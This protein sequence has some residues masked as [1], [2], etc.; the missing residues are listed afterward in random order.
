MFLIR[1][2]IEGLRKTGSRF[3]RGH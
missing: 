2:S 1:I 3:W